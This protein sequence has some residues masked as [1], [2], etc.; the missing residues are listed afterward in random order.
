MQCL[1]IYRVVRT[2]EVRG[3]T[4]LPEVSAPWRVFLPSFMRNNTA[5]VAE[6]PFVL[7]QYFILCLL[8]A[9]EYI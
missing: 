2:Q 8:C 4:Q 9:N 6:S 7:V 5:N 1:P 3:M